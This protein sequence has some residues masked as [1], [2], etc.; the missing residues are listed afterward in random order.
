MSAIARRLPD[1]PPEPLPKRYRMDDV[2][3]I[4]L[5]DASITPPRVVVPYIPKDLPGLDLRGPRA[6]R[7]RSASALRLMNDGNVEYVAQ[8]SHLRLAR[9]RA[10]IHGVVFEIIASLERVESADRRLV[11]R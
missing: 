11:Y 8:V 1:N 7:Y 6:I 3:G 5:L 9:S 4:A 2:L 10:G